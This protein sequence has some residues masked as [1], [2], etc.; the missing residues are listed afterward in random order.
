MSTMDEESVATAPAA[1]PEPTPIAE[2]EQTPAEQNSSRR[3]LLALG[4]AAVGSAFVS[5]RPA[6]AQRAVRPYTGR[7]LPPPAPGD[8]I[9]RLVRRV[10][11][12]VTQEELNRARAL[13]FRGYLEYQ[14]NPAAIDDKTVE[15]F[16]STNYPLLAEVGANLYQQGQNT[17]LNQLQEGTLYRAAFSRRQLYERM[18]EFWTDH[19]NISFRKVEYLKVVDDREVIRKHALGKFPDLLR[20]SAHSGAMLDYLDNTRSRGKNVNQNYARELMELHTLGVDGGYTQKDVEEVTRCLTGWTI[21]GRAGDFRF[22][23]TGHDFTAKAVLGTS[24]PA[25]ATTVGAAAIQDGEKVLD[26]LLAHP[27]TAKFI[28]TKMIRWLLQYDPP[29]TL[30]EKVAATFTRTGGDIPSM[31]RDILTASNLLAAPAKYRQPYQLALA[32]LRATQ[33]TVRSIAAV[34]RQLSTLGQGLFL[35]EE[36]DGYPDYVDWWAGMILQRWNFT[37]FITGLATGDLVVD[38]NPLL[39][40]GTAPGVADAISAQAFGGEMPAALKQEITTFLGAGAITAARVRE[41]FALALG[42]SAFQWY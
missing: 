5:A 6:S 27:S 26:I 20:A 12:G 4:L 17:V 34:N 35:W 1:P 2:S 29:V 39:Q 9:L 14:L 42:S 22:D 23:P 7:P 31:I 36:P 25:M 30:V 11:N 3:R 38:V 15:T 10:T 13:G 28:S 16:V 37:T 33:P 32:S 41:A 21:N 8:S 24:I 40:F 18:V 19:F